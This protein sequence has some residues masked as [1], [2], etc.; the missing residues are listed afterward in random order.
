[1]V[2]KHFA[3]VYLLEVASCSSKRKYQMRGHGIPLYP[4]VQEAGVSECAQDSLRSLCPAIG[5][6]S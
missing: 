6:A 2:L 3:K 1:M 5:P 4:S